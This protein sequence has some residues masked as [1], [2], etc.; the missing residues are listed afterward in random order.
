MERHTG[1]PCAVKAASTVRRGAVGKVPK[2]NSLAV[3]PT[4]NQFTEQVQGQISG[5]EAAT[6]FELQTISGHRLYASD[7]STI[8]VGPLKHHI[9]NSAAP[10]LNPPASTH[11]PPTAPPAPPSQTQNAPAYAKSLVVYSLP[12]IGPP[13]STHS[14]YAVP[15]SPLLCANSIPRSF[16]AVAIPRLL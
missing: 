2:G 14:T 3:Y 8:V 6:P 4:I 7:Y 16:S 12:E 11:H 10:T 13:L 5:C 9:A 1:E 15:E